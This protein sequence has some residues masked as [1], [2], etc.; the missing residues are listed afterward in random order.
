MSLEFKKE[1]KPE[2]WVCVLCEETITQRAMRNPTGICRECGASKK[3]VKFHKHG[4]ICADC[5]SNY[6]TGYRAEN[7][8]KIL[9]KKK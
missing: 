9:A 2:R 8:D 7:N 5:K 6:N 4:N 1:K 3:N